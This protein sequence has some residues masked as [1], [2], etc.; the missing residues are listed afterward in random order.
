MG[1]VEVWMH[2]TGKFAHA[3]VISAQHS[4]RGDPAQHHYAGLLLATGV[5]ILVGF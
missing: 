3:E 2:S 4:A 5:L 1:N